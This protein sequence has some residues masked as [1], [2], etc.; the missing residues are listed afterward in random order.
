[1]NRQDS[2]SVRPMLPRPDLR[3]LLSSP[4]RTLLISVLIT[5]LVVRMNVIA[6]LNINWD[7][8]LY[9]SQI[10]EYLRGDLDLKLQTFHVH[11]F[12]WLPG[13]S[14]NEVDQVIAGRAVML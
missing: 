10:Y 3:R 6:N 4:V 2:L 5:A 1:M 8:F 11:F 9:L 14:V 7:E 13:V 12:G